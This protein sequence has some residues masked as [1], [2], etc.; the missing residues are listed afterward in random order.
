[1]STAPATTPIRAPADDA[2]ATVAAAL[3]RAALT[4]QEAS[5]SP[6]L[7]AELLLGTVLGRSRAGLAVVGDAPLGAA[8]AREFEQLLARRRAGAPVAYLTG[9]REFWSLEFAVSPAVLV[10]RPETELL[11][12]LALAHLPANGEHSV[13]DLGTGSGAIAIAIAHERP[14][15][16]VTGTDR[17]AAALGV[18][19]ANGARLVADRV[20]WCGGS[21][22]DAVPGER[23]D[24]I[25]ANPPY[26]AAGDDALARLAAEP[27][28]ALSP[29]ATGLEAFATIIASAPDHLREGG[30]LALEHGA[31]QAAALAGWFAHARFAA[32]ETRADHAGLPRVTFAR[33]H[34]SNEEAS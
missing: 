32:I 24:V 22:F 23:F 11:V 27:F 34:S 10:P 25:L 21:W 8:A 15:A 29:G 6:R 31:T 19:R 3:R 5:G 1:M 12:E 4:L 28:E 20:R 18:A 7:D 16:R 30:I 33:F 14:R 13:L 17:S 2:L 26:V 9:A